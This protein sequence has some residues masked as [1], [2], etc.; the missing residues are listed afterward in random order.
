VLFQGQFCEEAAVK[1]WIGLAAAALAPMFG[2]TTPGTAMAS[3]GVWYQTYQVNT[4]GLFSDIAAI[5]KTNVWAVGDLFD[6]RGNTI[7]EPLIRHFNGTGW[8]TV[9]IPGSPKFESDWVDA[10]ARNNVWVGGLPKSTVAGSTVYRFDGSRWHRIPV[11]RLTY[12]QGVAV[13]SPKSVWAFGTSATIFPP[14]GNLSADVFHWNGSK[15]RGY[16][17]NF[18][19][20]SISASSSRNVWLAGLNKQRAAAYKWNGYAWHSVAMPHPVVGEG[21]GV[22]VFSTSNVW[23]GWFSGTGSFALHPYGHHWRTLTVPDSVNG[24]TMNIVPDGEGGYWFGD[25]AI[26]T[27]NTWTSEPP[28]QVT[29]GF[30]SVVRI[31]GT[32]SF[33]QPAGVVNADSSV[34]KPTIYRFDL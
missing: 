16:Y 19:P 30:A 5:S 4:A 18:L 12:L 17:L 31:P 33:L 22:A 23:I 10:S 24:D 15:W 9:T 28:I 26:L 2:L 6:N 8:K 14:S 25:A 11:P 27:G 34:Q 21:P 7:H 20:Q 32:E 29:G 1:R 3:S 13:L